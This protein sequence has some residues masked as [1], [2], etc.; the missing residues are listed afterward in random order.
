MTPES[1]PQYCPSLP[2]DNNGVDFS[3]TIEGYMEMGCALALGIFEY[4]GLSL[5][6]APTPLQ[7]T[8]YMAGPGTS[9]SGAASQSGTPQQRASG[10]AGVGPS[11]L[12]AVRNG[13]STS[14]SRGV[15]SE[16]AASG[17][18]RTASAKSALASSAALSRTPSQTSGGSFRGGSGGGR[19]GGG[20]GSSAGDRGGGGGRAPSL[21]QQQ[22]QSALRRYTSSPLDVR[23]GSGGRGE[24]AAGDA[25]GGAGPLLVVNGNRA[26]S[27]GSGS[28]NGISS[29][30]AGTRHQVI[31]R[32]ESLLQIQP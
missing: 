3:N 7:S 12:Q 32:F 15:L 28:R 10:S 29:R 1:V 11:S 26:A 4:Y 30:R 31:V 25:G 22:Q 6:P 21:Q 9:G 20:G 23:R 5:P 17:L 13:G 24:G 14:F 18:A 2:G 8:F 16:A 19:E 27:K